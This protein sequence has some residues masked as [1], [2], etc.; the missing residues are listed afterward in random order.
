MKARPQLILRLYTD[1]F[2]HSEDIYRTSTGSEEGPKMVGK[3]LKLGWGWAWDCIL[4]A[5][6]GGA[7]IVVKHS[8]DNVKSETATVIDSVRIQMT[9]LTNFGNRLRV[10]GYV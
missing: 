1:P 10:L 4:I 8:N 6:G 2:W 9:I 7:L 5:L 3:G